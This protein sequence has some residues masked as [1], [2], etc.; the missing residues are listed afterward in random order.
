MEP[1]DHRPSH[2]TSDIPRI[3]SLLDIFDELG[4]DFVIFEQSARDNHALNVCSAF[5]DK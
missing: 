3:L 1:Q 2:K 4:A 5:T